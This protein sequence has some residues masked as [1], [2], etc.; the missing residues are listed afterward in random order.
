MNNN[1][2]NT[3]NKIISIYNS[4]KEEYYKYIYSLYNKYRDR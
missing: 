2:Y 1:A 3:A 4:R